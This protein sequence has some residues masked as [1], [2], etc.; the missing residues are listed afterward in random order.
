MRLEPYPIPF[1][2]ILVSPDIAVRRATTAPTTWI[3]SNDVRGIMTDGG[4]WASRFE[5]CNLS[6][7]ISV[8]GMPMVLPVSGEHPFVG[9]SFL[10]DHS[11]R[12]PCLKNLRST[13]HIICR[14]AKIL[15]LRR[16]KKTPGSAPRRTPPPSRSA[17]HGLNSG[18]RSPGIRADSRGRPHSGG[19]TARP[20]HCRFNYHHARQGLLMEF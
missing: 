2:F 19:R 12:E 16:D 10:E 4:E 20:Q 5:R 1:S 14:G 17:P 18:G 6:W 8:D 9:D 7:D 13:P 11:I 15:R 3:R